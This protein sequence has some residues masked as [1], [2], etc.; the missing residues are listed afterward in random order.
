[1]KSFG[2]NGYKSLLGQAMGLFSVATSH[3]S[4]EERNILRSV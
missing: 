3:V 4:I 1:M 2:T